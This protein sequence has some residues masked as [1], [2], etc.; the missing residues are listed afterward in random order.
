MI[1]KLR[2][3]T[4]LRKIKTAW[5]MSE[6]GV[7]F[8]IDGKM[9]GLPVGIQNL[10]SGHQNCYLWVDKK[11]K[12][13]SVGQVAWYLY[14]GQWPTSEVDHIDANPQ[15]HRKENL[16]IATRQQQCMNRIAGKAGRLNKGVYKRNYGDKWSAQIWANG[17]CKNLGTYDSE[18]K[19]VQ[20]RIEATKMFHGNFANIKSYAGATK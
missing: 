5:S 12:G 2:T 20:A 15:N 1:M 19:A 3:E 18:E 4:E 8:W 17:K 11:L 6:D 10:K 7:L 13:Y 14:T 9:K 16:R